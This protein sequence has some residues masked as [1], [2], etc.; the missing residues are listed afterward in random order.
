MRSLALCLALSLFTSIHSP[1]VVAQTDSIPL[2][3]A[4]VNLGLGSGKVGTEPVIVGGLDIAYQ[5]RVHLISG[6]FLSLG[7]QGVISAA[8]EYSI[9]Y[10]RFRQST[11]HHAALS[12]GPS[13][14][15]CEYHPCSVNKTGVGLALS[16]Q[17]FWTS[18]RYVGLGLYAFCDINSAKSFYGGMVAL[19]LG[20][21]R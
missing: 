12:A 11:H 10:G 3:L 21:F 6:R 1:P 15:I 16:F 14:V 7:D 17:A 13:L 19:R 9:L 8:T 5:R 2:N 20:R 4:W 18:L